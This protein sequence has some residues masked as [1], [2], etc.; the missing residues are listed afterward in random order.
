MRQV[1]ASR[2]STNQRKTQTARSKPMPESTAF[3][4]T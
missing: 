3:M 4:G 1:H 2:T